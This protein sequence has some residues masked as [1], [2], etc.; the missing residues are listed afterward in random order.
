MTCEGHVITD[1]EYRRLQQV[2]VLL[3]PGDGAAPAAGEL[4]D[5]PEL[6]VRAIR[7]V[8]READQVHQALALLPD[9]PTW[10]SLEA[11][12]TAQPELFEVLAA[13][14]SGAYFMSPVALDAIGYPHGPRTAASKEQI[15]DELE[16]GI[17]EPVL[18]RP[19]LSREV[20]A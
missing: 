9:P 15:V 8:G 17:L 11:L 20:P 19:S 13:V 4:P 2:T 16:T 18:E 10:E 12:D 6:L 14:T 5:L 3:L 7:A 1:E